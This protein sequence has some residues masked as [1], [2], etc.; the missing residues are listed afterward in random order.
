MIRLVA[1]RIMASRVK[2]IVSLKVGFCIDI[3][4]DRDTELAKERRDIELSILR[5]LCVQRASD[6]ESSSEVELSDLGF[7]LQVSQ[8]SPG[9]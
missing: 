2:V 9:D 4:N 5:D 8:V 1:T 6:D 3:I 7:L